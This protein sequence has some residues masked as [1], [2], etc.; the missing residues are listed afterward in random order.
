MNK[1]VF[2]NKFQF[3]ESTYYSIC[4]II[5]LYDI[6]FFSELWAEMNDPHWYLTVKA[7]GRVWILTDKPFS[8]IIP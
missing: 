1:D 8:I 2:N 4:I 7:N 6:L 5:V 3:A